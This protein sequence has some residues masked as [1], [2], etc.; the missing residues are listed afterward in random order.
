[1]EEP[2]PLAPVVVVVVESYWD[3]ARVGWIMERKGDWHWEELVGICVP[4]FFW[5]MPERYIDIAMQ[6]RK[7]PDS[8]PR[9]SLEE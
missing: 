2:D 7:A 8:N 5:E 4:S 1:L 9:R 6:I 3:K